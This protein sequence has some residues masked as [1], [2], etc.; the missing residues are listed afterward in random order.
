MKAALKLG[1]THA[2]IDKLCAKVLDAIAKTALE[3]EQIRE[4]T[5]GAARSLGD[6]G[7]KK[8][9]TTTLPLAL[10]RL[11]VEGAIRRVPTNGR[12]DQQ[13]YKYIAWKPNPLDKFKQSPE[14]CFTT[15]ARKYWSW[16]GPA[17][18]AEF[19]WFS[20]QGVKAAKE[21][22]APLKLVPLEAGAD[23]LILPEDLDS[24]KSF[25][26]PK[27]P[28]YALVGSI[29]SL[30]LLRRSL[31]DHVEPGELKHRLIGHLADLPSHAIVDRGRLVGLWEYDPETSSIARM[32]FLKK[33]DKSLK[34]AVER[35]A[36]YVKTQ[37]G[38]ARSF[39]LDSPKSRAPRIQALREEGL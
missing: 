32:S 4:A 1:V 22:V 26:P 21:T 12:L 34:D 30:F 16:T 19:Q 28:Q 11:Q 7:K 13:R 25:K 39:S 14:E 27:D 33:P 5:G 36:E 18:L 6:E 29:D 8:G 23:R 35:M 17:T 31:S 38:D 9:L 3:P 10:G 2:E 37:L 20:G 15:L 24:L